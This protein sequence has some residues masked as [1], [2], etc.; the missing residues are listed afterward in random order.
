MAKKPKVCK[1]VVA[2]LQCNQLSADWAKGEGNSGENK[3][4]IFGATET[5]IDPNS[6]GRDN[7]DSHN[8]KSGPTRFDF[9]QFRGAEGTIAVHMNANT[10]GH[11]MNSLLGPPTSIA[12]NGDN[13]YTA[14]FEYKNDTFLHNGNI[15]ALFYDGDV[16]WRADGLVA[17][18][19]NIA[20]SGEDGPVNMSGD[21]FGK[22]SNIVTDLYADKASDPSTHGFQRWGFSVV[23]TT[24]SATG[25]ANDATEYTANITVD[26][27]INAIAIT[28]S[29][30]QTIATLI[31]EINADLTDAQAEFRSIG[32][33]YIE[34]RSLSTGIA[35]IIA[36]V[37]VDLFAGLTDGNVAA[38]SAV[39]GYLYAES[40]LKN[41]YWSGST[42]SVNGSSE[43][44]IR[45]LNLSL[46][47][48]ITPD[49]AGQKTYLQPK[50]TQSNAALTMTLYADGSPYYDKVTAGTLHSLVA[51]FAGD[52]TIGTGTRS[53]SL[54]VTIEKLKI[55][56][57]PK[58]GDYNGMASI[59]ITGQPMRLDADASTT[60]VQFQ[61]TNTIS[62]YDVS[63]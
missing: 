18:A 39:N 54:V 34:V 13:T 46:S 12:D 11:F 62:S 26:G 7:S 40:L 47:R 31:T 60:V 35:S 51:T 42:F 14:L 22:Q 33:G 49:R 36:I 16:D 24:A 41:K 38:E 10:I 8:G 1:K 44:D 56:D 27:D 57:M 37:D 55:A 48:D 5:S 21:F 9:D 2:F 23:K 53:P 30:A 50:P 43:N 3:K 4:V 58:P 28:G 25:L 59:D 20:A 32:N 6:S 19:F 29:T 52:D 17:N 15:G 63:Q 45:D 61:L